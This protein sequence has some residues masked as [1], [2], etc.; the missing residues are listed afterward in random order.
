M[1]SRPWAAE[2]QA[3]ADTFGFLEE[4]LS[5]TEDIRS[6]NA[7]SYVLD[8]FYRLTRDQMRLAEEASH[9]SCTPPE[10]S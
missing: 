7:R 1:T 8:R 6:N 4:R 3:A 2:R 5:G 10:R 9:E